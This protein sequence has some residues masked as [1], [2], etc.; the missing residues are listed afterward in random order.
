MQAIETRYYGPTNKR[1]SRIRATSASGI[2]VSVQIAPEDSMDEAHAKAL[3]ALCAKLGDGWSR[4]PWIAGAGKRGT[5]W[6]Q[7]V[8]FAQRVTVAKPLPTRGQCHCKRGL[9]RDNCA[10]CE[11]TGVAID[12][13][14]FHASKRTNA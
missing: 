14:A 12:W 6:V 10:N 11:G 9:E 8:D 4:A 2:Y 7:S 13:E 5:V 3:R 1:G